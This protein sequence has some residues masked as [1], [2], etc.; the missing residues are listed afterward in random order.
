MFAALARG[1]PPPTLAS[2]PAVKPTMSAEATVAE[3]WREWV[4]L[5]GGT[6]SQRHRRGAE[7]LL[8]REIEL[9]FGARPLREVSR[10]E[11]RRSSRR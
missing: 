8:E 5:R 7:R 3:R 2:A 6:W 9:R 1:E 10:E 11:W 4:A